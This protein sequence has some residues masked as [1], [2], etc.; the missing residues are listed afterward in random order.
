MERIEH[1]AAPQAGFTP[2]VYPPQEGAQVRFASTIS[3]GNALAVSVQ[4][5]SGFG[6]LIKIRILPLF[7]PMMRSLESQAV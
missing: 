5:I 4:V 6:V 1:P 2:G 7:I 3:A